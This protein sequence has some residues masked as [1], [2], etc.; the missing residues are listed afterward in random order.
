MGDGQGQGR[1]GVLRTA[2]AG[3]LGLAAVPSEQAARPGPR[4]MEVG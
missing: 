2:V 4:N 1:R 3:G